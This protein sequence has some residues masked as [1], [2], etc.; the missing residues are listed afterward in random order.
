MLFL[1]SLIPILI[2]ILILKTFDSFKFVKWNKMGMA[3]LL[4]VISCG[5]AFLVSIVFEHYGIPFYSWLVEEILK[6]L[7]AVLL[8]RMFRIVFFAESLCYGAAI[9][10][11]FAMLEN[12]IYIAYNP[13]MLLGAAIFRGVVTSMLHL[14][15]SALFLILLLFWEYKS[16]FRRILA[17]ILFIL[18]SMAIHFIYNQE[19]FTLLLRLFFI[20]PVFLIIFLFINYYNE[21]RLDNWLDHSIMFDVTLLTAINNGKLSDTNTGKYLLS[22]KE[23]FDGEVFFDMICYIRLY[24]ELTIG[25]KSRMMLNEAGLPINESEEEKEKQHAMVEEFKALRSHIGMTGESILRPVVKLTKE[26]KKLLGI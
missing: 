24:L 3:L 4:G 14:G 18:P 16:Q 13:H 23:Q 1:V 7:M 22:V 10:A 5:L 9:G 25:A 19:F 12:F 17:A 21:K 6:A 8:I 15:C 2:F 20:I 26:D 11:G